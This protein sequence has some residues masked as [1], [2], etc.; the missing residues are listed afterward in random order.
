[1]SR[2]EQASCS[3]ACSG[4]LHAIGRTKLVG[5]LIEHNLVDEFR[6]MIDPLVLGTGKRIFL[7]EGVARPLRLID[8][9]VTTTDAIIATYT[10]RRLTWC[11]QVNT[12][13]AKD[14]STRRSR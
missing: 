11:T 2:G 3:N 12:P 1:M 8:S 7:N 14:P 9:Q 10:G 5:A 6:L 13:A 4:D